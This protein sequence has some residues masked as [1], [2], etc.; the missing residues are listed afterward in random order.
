M[1][2]NG[3]EGALTAEDCLRNAKACEEQA[4]GQH[5]SIESRH[6]LAESCGM[7]VQMAERLQDPPG[8]T[9]EADMR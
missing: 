2:A 7:L 6:A 3:P 9:L 8:N 4:R 1:N 5:I